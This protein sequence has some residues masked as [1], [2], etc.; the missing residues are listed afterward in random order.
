M[1]ARTRT[2]WLVR[3]AMAA[4]LLAPL[5]IF[6]FASWTSYRN[7]EA[8]TDER[9]ARSLDVEEEEAQ[10]TFQLVGVALNGVKDLVA[11]MSAEDIRRDGQRL[12]TLLQKLDAQVP[13]IQSIWI[14]DKDGRP[15]VSS[16]D[17]VPSDLN[18]ADRDFFRSHLRGDVGT[19]Y[20]QIYESRF[21]GQP[22]F[23]VSQRLLHDGA[24][25]GVLEISVLPSNF[26]H[27][28]ATLA[29]AE[30]QQFSLIRDDGVFLARYP[31]AP[32]GAPTR[33][34]E[35][36]GF[37]RTTAR[38]PAG[39][40]FTTVSPIDHIERR[41]AARRLE[42]TPLYVTTGFATATTRREWLSGMA[43]HLIYGVPV[44]LILFFSLFAVL[45]RTQRLYAEI[46]R[47]SA[48]EE[49]L[50]QSQK[51][52]AIGHLTGGVAHDFNNLLTIIIGNLEAAQLQLERWTDGAQVK[53]S[54]RLENA[55]HGAQRAATLTK[56][57][58]AFSRQQ[59][60][61]P[62]VLDVNRVLNGLSD[63]LRRALGEDVS[64]EIVGGGGVWPVEADAAELEAAMLNLAVNARDA[65]P[66]GGKLT[67][68]AS[69]SYLDES[70]CRQNGDVKPGQY[71]QIAVTD[72]GSG[73]AKE[74]A[75]RAF[76]PFFTTKQS[77]QGTGLGL[78]QVYGFVKQSGGHVKIYSEAGDGTT[79]RVYLPRF[80]G[81]PS[82]AEVVAATPARGRSGECVL[83][84]EDDDDVRA[85]VVETLQ[86]S[87]YDVLEAGGAEG[88]LRLI[89][90]RPDIQ[91]LLTDV[92]MPEMNGRKLAGE[93]K[94]R[95]PKLKVLYMTG[96]SRN[97]IVHQGR[98]DPGVDLIQKPVTSEQ[99]ARAVRKAFDA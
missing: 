65:M 26:F 84:V 52:D 17:E 99:L 60:L 74:V 83:V 85:Y 69:N 22:Y 45:L 24:F 46:S 35:T 5:L 90:E 78:S 42:G 21:G 49:A 1:Q 38:A 48:A 36:S 6:A 88:A 63:F 87:G 98:L 30:G 56:R 27:F 25:M 95:R 93:A 80:R 10:R 96:Y 81:Q 34:D 51:L 39:G 33:L 15:L 47:R 92:V 8:L 91:L 31:A 72:S 55:M 18:N 11:G 76:E 44:T 12:H 57:L 14:Y 50:R 79:V 75:E 29:Y 70:Y 64:L 82:A 68:E 97:A 94:R 41:F 20:G 7:T 62:A 4:S 19:Y 73:M 28:F 16:W 53:L 37:R 77:G 3:L 40:F 43:V 71:V 23:T 61:N 32:P 9:L 58:L 2:I 86:S 89:D 59:P 66:D 54:R 13:L 67:V